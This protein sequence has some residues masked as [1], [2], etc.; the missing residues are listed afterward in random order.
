MTPAEAQRRV[1]AG[2]CDLDDVLWRWAMHLVIP[3][4][5]VQP[6]L[7]LPP[8]AMQAIYLEQNCTV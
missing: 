2:A 7:P 3:V 8:V 5:K 1:F 4:L 6:C